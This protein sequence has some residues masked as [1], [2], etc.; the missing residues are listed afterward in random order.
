MSDFALFRRIWLLIPVL[1]AVAASRALGADA[2][3]ITP[4]APPALTEPAV[5]TTALPGLPTTAGLAAL[6]AKPL[7]AVP[8]AV[9]SAPTDAGTKLDKKDLPASL[10]ALTAPKTPPPAVVPEAVA[11]TALPASDLPKLAPIAL[12]TMAGLPSLDSSKKPSNAELADLIA[13]AKKEI[14]ETAASA[15]R[16]ITEAAVLVRK[17]NT[18]QED[19]KSRSVA[20]TTP[21][22]AKVGL[23]PIAQAPQTYPPGSEIAIVLSQDRFYPA[24]IHVRSGIASTLVFSSVNRKPAALVIEP[25]QMMRTVASEQMSPDTQPEITRELGNDRVTAISFEPAKGK[26]NFHDALGAARGTI[27]VE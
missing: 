15:K 8:P 18:P 11:A 12:P 13:T 14:E 20:S 16:S 1:L 10:Q 22:A 27:I 2:A 7:P 17:A 26:Y 23:P 24:E 4:P 5:P 9:P 21:G 25:V 3:P 6:T 19:P